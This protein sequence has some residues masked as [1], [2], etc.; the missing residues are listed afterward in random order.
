MKELL[1][2][3]QR[4]EPN[5]KTAVV[6]VYSNH[7]EDFLGTIHWRSGWRCYV[8]SYEPNVDMSVS[9]HKE[10]IKCMEMLELIRKENNNEN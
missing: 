3:K 6:E 8:M 9:C 1:R 7:S 10:L 2:F 4:F 5:I